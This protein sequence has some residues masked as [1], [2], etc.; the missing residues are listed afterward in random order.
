MPL[1]TAILW[2]Y[3]LVVGCSAVIHTA[4]LQCCNA[5][6]SGHMMNNA[7][8]QAHLFAD[9]TIHSQYTA[10]GFNAIVQNSAI[11]LTVLL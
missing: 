4:T 2:I 9:S 5:E 10:D 6:V 1:L 8:A 3:V 11:Q 7:C